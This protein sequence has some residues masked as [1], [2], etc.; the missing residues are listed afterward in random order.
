MQDFADIPRP[1]RKLGLCPN[2]SS[3][4]HSGTSSLDDHPQAV[5]HC[6]WGS[7]GCCK[8]GSMCWNG[9]IQCIRLC[10]WVAVEIS[11]RILLLPLCT[12]SNK[13]EWVTKAISDRTVSNQSNTSFPL[14]STVLTPHRQFRTVWGWLSREEVPER[15]L[16]E[17]SGKSLSFSRSGDVCEIMHAMSQK[18][19]DHLKSG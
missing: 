18:V 15:P 6:L 12:D 5:W 8:V 19:C 11:A 16:E 9:L 13:K 1:L 14:C 3:S 17:L 4:C 7:E 10:Q 2:S